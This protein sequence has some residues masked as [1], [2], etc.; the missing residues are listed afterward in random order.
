MV[1]KLDALLEK[2]LCATRALSRVLVWVGGALMVGAAVLVTIEVALRKLFNISIGGADELSGYAFGI[3]TAFALSHA[4]FARAHIRVDAVA[5]LLPLQ[6]R[7]LLGF[8][9]LS[10]LIGFAALATWSAASMLGD[11]IQHGSRSITPMRT[12][13]AWVQAPWLF[14]WALFVGGGVLLWLVAARRW[15]KRDVAGADRLIG[16]AQIQSD[17]KPAQ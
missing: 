16:V 14:G 1:N 17:S 3:A 15:M 2:L 9:G 7:L 5:R 8:F 6:W 12:P 11:S 4:L 13:L 10:L